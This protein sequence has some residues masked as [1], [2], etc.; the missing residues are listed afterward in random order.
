MNKIYYLI[1]GGLIFN[2]SSGPGAL[3]LKECLSRLSW[4]D[5]LFEVSKHRI[6]PSPHLQGYGK[7]RIEPLFSMIRERY[8]NPA[9]TRRGTNIA[10][11]LVSHVE[12]IW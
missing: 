4:K 10:F 12:I 2:S 7:Y 8:R 5:P 11:M 1:I 3:L 9:S 6:D